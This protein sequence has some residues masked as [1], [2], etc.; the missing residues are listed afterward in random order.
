MDNKNWICGFHSVQEVLKN[1]DRKIFGLYVSDI[2][3]VPENFKKKAKVVEKSFFQK[4]FGKLAINHQN[5]AVEV[6]DPIKHDL[7]LDIKNNKIK[8][9]VILD[10]ITD[11]MNIGS[12]IR[13]CCAF[14]IDGI[15]IENRNLKTFSPLIAKT[16]SGGLEHVNVYRIKNINQIINFLKENDFWIHGLDEKSEINIFKHKWSKKNVI[17]LGS[18][19]NGMKKLVKSNCDYLLKIPINKKISSL[20]VSNSA[21][22]CLALVSNQ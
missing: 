7:K 22:V 1:K 19:G 6:N 16:A 3:K 10:G 2:N 18:E 5:I 13:S 12:I 11:P 15:I 8:N 9:L 14:N 4:K 20:N 21:A 17:V